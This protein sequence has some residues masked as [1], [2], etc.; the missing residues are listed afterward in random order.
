M[1]AWGG[2]GTG[3][4]AARRFGPAT[5]ITRTRPE[6]ICDSADAT[7][8]CMPETWPLTMSISAAAAPLYGTCVSFTPVAWVKIAMLTWGVLLMPEVAQLTLPGFALR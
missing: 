7:E 5:A 3:G 6:R 1:G 8:L 4:I 2:G